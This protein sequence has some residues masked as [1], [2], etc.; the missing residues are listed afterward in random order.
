VGAGPVRLLPLDGAPVAGPVVRAP[1]P[2][3][4]ADWR[5]LLETFDPWLG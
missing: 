2:T 3:P 1:L 5:L 4:Y